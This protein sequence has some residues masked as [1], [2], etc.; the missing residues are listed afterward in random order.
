M[1][2]TGLVSVSR[3]TASRL[4]DFTALSK[5][6]ALVTPTSISKAGYT[7]SNTAAKA[8]PATGAE[9]AASSNLPPAVSP[10]LCSCMLTSLSCVASNGLSGEQVGSLFSTVCS[11][12]HKACDG[13]STDAAAGVYG[14]FSMCDA[15]SKLSF[16]MHQYYQNQM[17]VPTAC[18]FKGNAKLQSASVSPSCSALLSKSGFTAAKPA[19]MAAATGGNPKKNAAGAVLVP[20]SGV[21]LLQLGASLMIF[22]LAGAALILL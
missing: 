3:S 16:A 5:Q 18:D 8:C 17:Q 13:I 4:P 7:P 10:E 19:A 9:W 12:D 6:L 2:S 21:G 11:V 20:R 14:A 22:G 15:H 1:S